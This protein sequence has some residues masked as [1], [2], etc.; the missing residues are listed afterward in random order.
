MEATT[1]RNRN[2]FSFAYGRRVLNQSSP[3]TRTA[4]SRSTKRP[5][6]GST[7]TTWRKNIAILKANNRI[8]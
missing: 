1:N 3:P 5:S 7:Y 8:N 4:V 6:D 2:V